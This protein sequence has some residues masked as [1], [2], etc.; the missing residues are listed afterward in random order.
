MELAKGKG[1]KLGSV[2]LHDA[3]SWLKTI[4]NI[5]LV[6]E[7]GSSFPKEHLDIK[8]SFFLILFEK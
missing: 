2:L 3:Q 5:P 8:C 7:R 1:Q 4:K 6:V